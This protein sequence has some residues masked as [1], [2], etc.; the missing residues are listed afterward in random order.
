MLDTLEVRKDWLSI[1]IVLTS[2]PDHRHGERTESIHDLGDR[3]DADVVQFADKLG[4]ELT[5]LAA[6]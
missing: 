6:N 3:V 5:S 4:S 2:S 1:T